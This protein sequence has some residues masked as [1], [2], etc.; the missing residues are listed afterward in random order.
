MAEMCSPQSWVVTLSRQPDLD[1][2]MEIISMHFVG[3]MIYSARANI[4]PLIIFYQV[5]SK[6]YF[7]K[8]EFLNYNF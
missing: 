1:E 2:C 6:F 7:G 5:K 4:G 8:I 3:Q